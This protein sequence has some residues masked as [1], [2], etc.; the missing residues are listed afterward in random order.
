MTTTNQPRVYP[1]LL[2][3]SIEF[4]T[5]GKKFKVLTGGKVKDFVNAPY[6]IHQI[7][8][9]EIGKEP[10]V[11]EL[12]HSWHPESELRRLTQFGSCRFG[13]LDY[14]PDVKDSKLQNGEYSFCAAR[15][16]CP[17]EGILCKTP[18]YRGAELSFQEISLLQSLSGT[19]TNENIAEK[20][21]LPAGTFHLIKKNLYRKLN[22][23]T[24]QEAALVARDLNLL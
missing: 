19:D 20:H 23:Q 11:N 12:L 2:C 14:H 1:G 22:I 8:K 17:G 6:S 5:S 16:K 10:A 13:G 9:D 18:R 4:F 24:K 15:G 3:S 21:K 7:L